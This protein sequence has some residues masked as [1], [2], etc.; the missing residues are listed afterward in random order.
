MD[1]YRLIVFCFGRRNYDEF[2]FISYIYDYPEVG[3]SSPEGA[4][5]TM[6]GGGFL[7]SGLL[8]LGLL[9]VV[10]YMSLLSTYPFGMTDVKPE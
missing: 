6:R 7:L 1:N 8:F 10:T 3:P 5:L 2:S 9:F 4:Q